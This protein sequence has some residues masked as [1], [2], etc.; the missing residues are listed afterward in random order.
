MRRRLQRNLRGIDIEI[1]LQRSLRGLERAIDHGLQFE[2][3][4]I[5]ASLAANEVGILTVALAAIA[6]AQRGPALKDDVL[7]DARFG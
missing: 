4:Q 7:K 6:E 1:A 3:L 2:V 5:D